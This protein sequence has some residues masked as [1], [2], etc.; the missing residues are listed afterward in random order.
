MR[1]NRSLRLSVVRAGMNGATVVVA[2]V[3]KR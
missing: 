3:N 1:V 2:V